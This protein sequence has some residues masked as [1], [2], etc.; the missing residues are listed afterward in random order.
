LAL[1][2]LFIKGLSLE[3]G[4]TNTFGNDHFTDPSPAIGD[5]IDVTSVTVAPQAYLELMHSTDAGP[6]TFNTILRYQYNYDHSI[7]S[8]PFA[9]AALMGS[10][11][12]NTNALFVEEEVGLFG[13]RLRIIP[14]GRVEAATGRKTHA[15]WRVGAVGSPIEWLDIKANVGTAFRYPTF[16]ELYFPDQGY[17]RGNPIL[18]DENSFNWD[19][20]IILKPPHSSIEVAYF[21]NRID[22]QI[23]FVPI[24]ATTIQPINTGRVK[25]QGIEATAM[26]E[27]F[28]WLR[29][30]ANYTWMDANFVSNGLG[31]PGRP[32]HKANAR[33]E[34]RAKW[35]S[36]FGEMQYVG[37][38]PLNTANTVKISSHTAA[39]AGTT[40]AFAKSFF[41]TFEVKD[42]TNVQIYDARGFPLP[43]RSYWVSVGA[44]T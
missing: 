40:I 8:S 25:S 23:M 26:V 13:E 41:F 17:L 35:A 32:R 7:D 4:A 33:A 6:A 31:L 14:S 15:S 34:L 12:R 30:D 29:I 28:K 1:D 9:G 44:K 2:E 10:H 36:L 21:Q 3:A 16:T 18:N 20:G 37:S 39:N 27:P 24:S 43:R 22:N 11:G 19:A 38:Y 5:P 42:L